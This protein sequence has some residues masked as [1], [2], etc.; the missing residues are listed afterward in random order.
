MCSRAVYSQRLF[1]SQKA[2]VKC[3]Y[4]YSYPLLLRKI[5]WKKKHCP[6]WAQNMMIVWLCTH[7]FIIQPNL[8]IQE[9]YLK[10]IISGFQTDRGP[11]KRCERVCPIHVLS[12]IKWNHIL[13]HDHVYKFCFVFI[14]IFCKLKVAHA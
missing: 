3:S 5:P 12:T 10:L 9:S 6:V 4:Y 8:F 7:L 11:C 2:D 13:Q 1:C 14:K